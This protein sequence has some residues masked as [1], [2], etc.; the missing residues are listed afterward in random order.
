[1]AEWITNF[2]EQAGYGGVALLM[3]LENVFPPIPSE[4]I[5]P[6][7]GF[8]ARRGEM[9][10]VL[11]ILAGSVGS[12]AGATLWYA[13]AR[14]LGA[15]RLRKWISR[16]GR[17]LATTPEEL[18]RAEAWFQRHGS[19]AVFVGRLVPAIRTLISVPAGV[20][21]MGLGSFL[22][23]TTLGSV[24]WTSGLAMAGYALGDRY[25]SASSAI[26]WVANGVFGVLVAWYLWRV[27]TYRKR[28]PAHG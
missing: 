2:L 27:A 15:A 3:L 10:P 8:A 16:H 18:D 23:W 19:M 11:V 13:A 12:V 17:W 7:A 5:M 9:H 6:F 1:M 25:E 4:L 28:Q 14:R 21:G 26:N 24:A 20:A 22:L